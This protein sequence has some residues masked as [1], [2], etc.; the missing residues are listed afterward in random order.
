M[1]HSKQAQEAEVHEPWLQLR[2]V[3]SG[4]TH[5]PKTCFQARNSHELSQF[6]QNFPESWLKTGE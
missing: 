5:P 1:A 3:R 2:L 6:D 4:K